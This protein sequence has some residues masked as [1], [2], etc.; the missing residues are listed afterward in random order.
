[1]TAGRPPSRLGD[2]LRCLDR[3]HR[4]AGEDCL[5][6]LELVGLDDPQ[7]GRHDTA[8]PQRHDVTRD[9]QAHVKRALPAVPPDQRLVVDVA[10]ESGD[11]IGGAVLVDEAEADAQQHDRADDSRVGQTPR[12][13]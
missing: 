5:V 3:G 12:E 1:M 8:D 6:A 7:V 4:F 9:E 10:M 13:R 11:G 2:R